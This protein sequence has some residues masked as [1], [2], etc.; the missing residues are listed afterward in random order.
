MSAVCGFHVYK[1]V[2]TPTLHEVLQT[3]R[4]LENREDRY[5]V[6]VLKTS[7]ESQTIVGHVPRELSK[8]FWYFINND[9]EVTCEIIGNRKRSQLLQGGMEIPCVYRFVGKKKH[10]KK[11]R[12]ML[13]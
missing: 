5:A 9:G 11:L 12:K 6:C 10:I 2:W 3:R 8:L 1:V 7:A 4:E 13:K